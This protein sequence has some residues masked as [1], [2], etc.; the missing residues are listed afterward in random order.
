M[1][2]LG[3]TLECG[4]GAYPCFLCCV[5]NSRESTTTRLTYTLILVFIT[6]ISIASHEGGV[7]S[8]L[9]LRQHRDNFERFCSQIGAGEGCYRIIGYI[10]VYRICLSL[11][12][13]HI[14][15]T[16]LTIAVSSSQ[17]FRGKIHN[18]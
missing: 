16:F 9:Y 10:G 2:C 8:S 3:R 4:F 12:T 17:T 15:M 6:F 18:G 7:L 5:K 14:L 13:F 11:F 1:G